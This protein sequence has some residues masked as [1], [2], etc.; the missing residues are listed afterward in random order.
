MEAWALRAL[1]RWPNV[2]A[3]FGW[4]EL[5]RR[6]RW[7]IQGELISRLQIIDTIN[8]N[9]EA[10]QHG[11]WFFQN[12]PQRGYVNLETAP[13]V[14]HVTG[15]TLITHT[16]LEVREPTAAYLDEEGSLL[17]ATEHG[18]AAL[19]DSDLEWA[20]ARFVCSGVSAREEDI[21]SA[22]ALPSGTHTELAMRIDNSMLPISRLDRAIAPQM[23]GF[24][25]EPEAFRS[26]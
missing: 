24:V 19:I 1:E 9:Y 13:L 22:L 16:H 15:N 18:P 3:L 8:R 21:L 11:R 17:I 12:G 23:L 5:D 25:R 7:L 14:A 2:P 4:L 26:G 10:D 20:L 6:G